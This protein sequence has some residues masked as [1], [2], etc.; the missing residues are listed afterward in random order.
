MECKAIVMLGVKR[1]GGVGNDLNKG[2]KSSSWKSKNGEKLRDISES[3]P[4]NLI[5]VVSIDFNSLKWSISLYFTVETRFVKKYL[6]FY[7]VPQ[8]PI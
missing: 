6:Q 7:R 2:E 5:Y 1:C 4:L 8:S 3:P